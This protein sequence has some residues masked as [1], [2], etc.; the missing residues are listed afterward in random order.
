MA[1][2]AFL[3]ACHDLMNRMMQTIASNVA[4]DPLPRLATVMAPALRPLV[5]HQRDRL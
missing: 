3:P 2:S 5:A 4:S 1:G